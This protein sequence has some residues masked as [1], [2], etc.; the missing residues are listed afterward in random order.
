MGEGG[1]ILKGLLTL[2]I[3]N[4]DYCGIGCGFNGGIGFN[5]VNVGV[6][7]GLNEVYVDCGSGSGFGFDVDLNVGFVFSEQ[8]TAYF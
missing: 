3:L 4:E 2:H 5:E 6:G 1:F 8:L 7:C